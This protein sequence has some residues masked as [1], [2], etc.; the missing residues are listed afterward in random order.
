MAR[1]PG[2]FKTKPGLNVTSAPYAVVFKNGGKRL[3]VGLKDIY[4]K[5]RIETVVSVFDR[6]KKAYLDLPTLWVSHRRKFIAEPASAGNS[7]SHPLS[8][9]GAL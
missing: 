6:H 5:V 1:H 7:R 3:Y 4:T 8:H 2:K 9:L